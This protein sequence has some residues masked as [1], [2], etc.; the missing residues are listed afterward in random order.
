MF[1]AG[2]SFFVEHTH[3]DMSTLWSTPSPR[4]F[5]LPLAATGDAFICSV[6]AIM[7]IMSLHGMHKPGSLLSRTVH[8]TLLADAE[9]TK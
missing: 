8:G 4:H 7:M 2:L 6:N 3:I 9:T 1:F 5:P